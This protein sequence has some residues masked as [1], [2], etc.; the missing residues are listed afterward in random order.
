MACA[1]K[2]R[3]GFFRG[4]F[5]G[6]VL[7]LALAACGSRTSSE[8]PVNGAGAAKEGSGAAG[9]KEAVSLPDAS[10]PY[11]TVEPISEGIFSS[12]AAVPARLAIQ[13]QALASVGAPLGGRVISVLVRPGD[14]VKAGTP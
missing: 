8:A 4:V 7:V 9:A 2:G 1:T 13:P 5:G 6:V 3:I 11:V 14:R 10:L 12:A